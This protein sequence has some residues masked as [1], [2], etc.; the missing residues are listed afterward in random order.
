VLSRFLSCLEK[1]LVGC[2]RNIPI[3]LIDPRAEWSELR[4]VN[5][6]P[7]GVTLRGEYGYNESVMSLVSDA[8]QQTQFVPSQFASARVLAALPGVSAA[9]SGESAFTAA[10]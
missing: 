8:A 1:P 6:L 7:L 2:W 9:V 3:T 10:S 4:L 5:S